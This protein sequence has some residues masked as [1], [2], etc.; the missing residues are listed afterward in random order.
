VRN[1]LRKHAHLVRQ[2]TANGLSVPNS[3]VRN[4]GRRCGIKQIRTF[5]QTDLEALLP[6][7]EQ[8]LAVRSS[9]VLLECLSQ[10]IN[11]LEQAVRKHL[12]R[13]PA[14]EQLLRCHGIGE[15]LAQ[16]IILETG[17]IGRFA[18]VGDYA[19][20]GRCGRSTKRSNG[21]HT[22]QGNAQNGHASLAWASREA[23]PCAMRLRPK[24]HRF[25]QRKAAKSHLMVA[26]TSV[27]H[28]LARACLYVMRD[29]VPFEI[30]RAFG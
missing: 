22:A 12:K 23:A 8:V 18:S 27:A 20:S 4:T 28:T 30:E 14:S 5:S 19:S 9:L 16:T 21:K 6:E 25:D 10:Q 26:R 17:P 11:T 29:L 1:G 3:L 13:T 15:L 24:R 7:A 2:H